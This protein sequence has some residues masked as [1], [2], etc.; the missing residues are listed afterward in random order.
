M[1]NRGN[2][3]IYQTKDGK[4][5][6][7]V[8]LENE[9]VWLTQAQ[10]AELFQKDRTVIGRYINNVYRE[11]ELERDI[12]CAKIAHVQIEDI[13][14]CFS[15]SDAASLTLI[16]AIFFCLSLILR[17]LLLPAYHNIPASEHKPDSDE[18]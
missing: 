18:Y 14:H 12:T 6:I 13:S 1:D 17:C 15:C 5:S 11:G 2:I 8:K 4:T 7:D 10:M 9:T 16:E 3:V